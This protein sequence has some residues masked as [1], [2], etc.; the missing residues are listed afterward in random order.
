MTTEFSR[1]AQRGKPEKQSKAR[2]GN[3]SQVDVA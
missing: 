2:E 3:G 1:R